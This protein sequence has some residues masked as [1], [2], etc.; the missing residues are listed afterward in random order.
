MEPSAMASSPPREES[1]RSLAPEPI[2][3]RTSRLATATTEAGSRFSILI[4]SGVTGRLHRQRVFVIRVGERGTAGAEGV[5]RVARPPFHGDLSEDLADQAGELERVPGPAEESNLGCAG[6]GAEHEI[7][8]GR[9]IVE[10]GLGVQLRPEGTGDVALQEAAQVGEGSRVRL[11]GTGVHGDL[12]AP[13][14]LAGFGAHGAVDRKPVERIAGP[15]VPDP[16][17]EPIRCELSQVGR[18]KVSRLLL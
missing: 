17:R 10:A 12:V 2:A 9:H 4:A 7:A 16:G 13:G 14:V 1:T 15:A 8:V 6:Y 5:Y 3:T 11:E 18:L